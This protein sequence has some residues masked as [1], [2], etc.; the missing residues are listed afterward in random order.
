MDSNCRKLHPLQ[1]LKCICTTLAYDMLEA[2]SADTFAVIDVH[3]NLTAFCNK[4]RFATT[5]ARIEA[6]I[7]FSNSSSV[8]QTSFSRIPSHMEV[9]SRPV[10]PS[11]SA[12]SSYY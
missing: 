8:A 11:A 10:H 6:R 4:L 1:N 3:A 7:C 9:H 12:S 2:P 5:K